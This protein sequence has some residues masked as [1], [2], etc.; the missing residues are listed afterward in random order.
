MWKNELD[1]ETFTLAKLGS[2]CIGTKPICLSNKLLSKDKYNNKRYKLP[3]VI[4]CREALMKFLNLE[5]E[6]PL[7]CLASLFSGTY[8]QAIRA[9]YTI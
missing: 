2:I 8:E 3:I 9:I 1:K 5:E 4:H 6:N 7:I